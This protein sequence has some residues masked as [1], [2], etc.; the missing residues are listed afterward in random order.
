L[1]KLSVRLRLTPS[2]V[3]C[4]LASALGVIFALLAFTWAEQRL[5]QRVGFGQPSLF[6]PL[7]RK[8]ALL[9]ARTSVKLAPM[10]YPPAVLLVFPTLPLTMGISLK[11]V[12]R[13]R[14]SPE[15]AI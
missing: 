15:A 7:A 2:K 3:A 6:I 12:E 8:L 13:Q 14:R 10:P 4:R 5:V 11:R 9:T 1:A